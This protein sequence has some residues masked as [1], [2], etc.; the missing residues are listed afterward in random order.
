MTMYQFS[1]LRDSQLRLGTSNLMLP[2]SAKRTE[3]Q[4]T[5]QSGIY[6]AAFRGAL[7]KLFGLPHSQSYGADEAF[8]SILE[9]RDPTGKTWILTAYEGPSGP[10]IGGEVRDTSLYVVAEALLQQIE[11]TPPADFEAIIYDDDTDHTVVY[12]CSNGS[13]YWREQQGYHIPDS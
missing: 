5:E 3:M 11:G 1:V 7:L 6:T 9:A 10:A 8:E 2:E 13:C 12:G 4:L